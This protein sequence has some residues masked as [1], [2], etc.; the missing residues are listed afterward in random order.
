MGLA[1][2]YR[3][4]TKDFASIASPLTSLLK[5]DVPLFWNDAQ[6]L[7]FN[8]SK[9]ALT[10]APVLAFPNYKL[11]FTLCTDASAFGIGAVLMQ[12]EDSWCLQ[13]IAF[14]SCVLNFAEYMYCSVTNLEALAVVWALKHFRDIIYNYP[15]TVYTDH[16][17]VTQLFNSKNLTGCLARWYLTI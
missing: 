7:S 11:P 10:Q 5:K 1:G 8:A 2:Y 13:V 14:A 12:S 16:T 17:A 6:Q 15:I 4:F 3:A 9:H